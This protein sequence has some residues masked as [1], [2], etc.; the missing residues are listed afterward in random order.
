MSKLTEL[1]SGQITNSD[2]I[3][4][5]L[6]SPDDMP[7]S[8]IIHW[9]TKPSV[10]DPR[11]YASAADAAVKVFA[12]AVVKLAQTRGGGDC[13]ASPSIRARRVHSRGAAVPGHMADAGASDDLP[14]R[15]LNRH[16]LVAQ[17]PVQHPR[18]SRHLPTGHSNHLVLNPQGNHAAADS[19]QSVHPLT[20]Q[21]QPPTASDHPQPASP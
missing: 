5:I 13:E 21:L 11:E 8:V 20:S 1:A 4:V 14:R 18:Q 9:P 12:A 16:P 10:L 7:A 6:S 17:H 19:V 2:A 15:T 3:T